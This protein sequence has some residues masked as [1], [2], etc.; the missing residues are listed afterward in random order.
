MFVGSFEHQLDDKGRVVLPAKFRERM[1][2]G[3]FITQ[4]RGLCLAVWTPDD[5]E[6]E[7]REVRER[8]KRG[9][10]DRSLLRSMAA[11]TFD[12]KP[13]S[14]GRIQLPAS[15]RSY[16]RITGA[17]TVAGAFDCIEL[18]DTDLWHSENAAGTAR[19]AG[20]AG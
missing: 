15:L 16:A 7:A 19:L 10:L 18:W 11:N 1:A 13:D 6:S 5:F 8:E 12:I 4:G 17:V 14:Q 20:T 3:G 9:E 2:T